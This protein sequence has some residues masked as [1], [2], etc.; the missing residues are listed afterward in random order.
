MEM[1]AA[2]MGII[3]C[4]IEDVPGLVLNAVALVLTISSADFKSTPQ[5]FCGFAALLVGCISAG[6]KSYLGEKL[7]QLRILK[8]E[9]EATM[10]IEVGGMTARK[11]AKVKRGS[12]THTLNSFKHLK[13]VEGHEEGSE[14]PLAQRIAMEK[15]RIAE[16]ERGSGAKVN[17]VL[18]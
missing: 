16:A 13:K 15:G 14:T 2:K 4:F 9:I 1:H 10:G 11:G 12:I 3:N 6:R 5:F 7:A 8:G 18:G 17:P